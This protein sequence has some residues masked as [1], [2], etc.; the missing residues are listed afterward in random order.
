MF[1]EAT[2][3]DTD[4]CFRPTASLNLRCRSRQPKPHSRAYGLLH[5]D[6]FEQDS[7]ARCRRDEITG[8]PFS[9]AVESLHNLVSGRSKDL[10]HDA[11]MRIGSE[12]PEAFAL[13]SNSPPD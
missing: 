12:T 7:A 11:V 4:G 10:N 8:S 13:E 5:L 9:G 2:S 3:G 1:A 6:G